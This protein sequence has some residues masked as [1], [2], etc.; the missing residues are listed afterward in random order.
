MPTPPH[1]ALAL[2]YV[3]L[4][5]PVL[6]NYIS[7]ALD[8]PDPQQALRRLS[9]M[10]HHTTTKRPQYSKNAD[11]LRIIIRIEELPHHDHAGIRELLGELLPQ[12]DT[13]D[14]T[15]YPN[16][17]LLLSRYSTAA[18]V[19]A[20]YPGYDWARSQ[21]G[22]ERSTWHLCKG[23]VPCYDAN[24]PPTL[25]F[26]EIYE[27]FRW[28]YHV[29][30]YVKGYDSSTGL[31]AAP[32][33][34]MAEAD[35]F[36]KTLRVCAYRGLEEAV[37]SASSITIQDEYAQGAGKAVEYLRQLF[38]LA[39][40]RKTTHQHGTATYQQQAVAEYHRDEI[41]RLSGKLPSAG[42]DGLAP[43]ARVIAAHATL[44]E[45]L[46]HPGFADEEV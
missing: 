45:N 7:E 5:E 16:F 26:G 27:N 38:A 30:G 15:M 22:N 10:I 35:G 42:A 46:S 25:P 39:S 13:T 2:A 31:C 23:F 6:A 44:L 29:V 19:P 20:L 41:I 3:Y 12:F 33:D 43:L 24:M 37:N 21:D 28:K 18:A 11:I 4:Y 1:L 36:S 17:G 34:T 9:T 8:G 40:E 32:L 14:A